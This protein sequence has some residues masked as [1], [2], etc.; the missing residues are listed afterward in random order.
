MENISYHI[1]YLL[2]L[3][4][5][6]YIK[7]LTWPHLC[8]SVPLLMAPLPIDTIIWLF[9]SSAASLLVPFRKRNPQSGL[10]LKGVVTVAEDAGPKGEEYQGVFFLRE[11]QC[12]SRVQNWLYQVLDRCQESKEK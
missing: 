12:W 6:K 7:H 9:A 11:T 8:V 2:Y 1:L 3:K 5:L 4:P 10:D